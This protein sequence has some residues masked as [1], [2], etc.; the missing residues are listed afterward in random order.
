MK[1]TALTCALLSSLAV[2]SAHA[3]V[4]RS[5]DYKEFGHDYAMTMV[6]STTSVSFLEREKGAKDKTSQDKADLRAIHVTLASADVAAFQQVATKF[7]ELAKKAQDTKPD[8]FTNVIGKV[9][10]VDYKINWDG[11]AAW[12]TGNGF[13]RPAEVERILSLLQQ[14]PAARADLAKGPA[15][16]PAPVAPPK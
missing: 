5:V 1:L 15:A 2:L 11:S 4:E 16:A 7:M 12:L 10:V 6:V 8:Q 9:G 14:L 13:L 3:D